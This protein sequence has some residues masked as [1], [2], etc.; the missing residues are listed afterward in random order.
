M[1]SSNYELGIT[2]VLYELYELYD[3]GKVPELYN[4]RGTLCNF[5]NCTFI[6]CSLFSA[7]V[8]GVGLT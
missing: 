8:Y 2:V 5:T 7:G 6:G 1:L 3:W 4:E